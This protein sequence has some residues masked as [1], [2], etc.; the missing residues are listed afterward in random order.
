MQLLDIE[1]LSLE[2]D[3]R[4]LAVCWMALSGWLISCASEAESWPSIVTRPT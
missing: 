1:R 2:Q 3:L 4:S